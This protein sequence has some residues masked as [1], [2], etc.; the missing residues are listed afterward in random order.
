MGSFREDVCL[1]VFITKIIFVRNN[2]RLPHFRVRVQCFLNFSRFDTKTS[3]LYLIIQAPQQLNTAVRTVARQITAPVKTRM[4]AHTKRIWKKTLCGELRLIQIA[5]R[6][7]FSADVQFTGHTHGN[8][9]HMRIEH[10]KFA[11]TDRS[12][13][14][15]RRR[16]LRHL[17]D[18]VP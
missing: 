9:L 18:Q 2:D 6:E 17:V 3:E 5:A 14:R 1:K 11:V 10:V 12:S 4:Q 8:R 7:T 13:N 15:N 16:V